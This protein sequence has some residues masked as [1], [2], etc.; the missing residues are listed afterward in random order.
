LRL[1]TVFGSELIVNPITALLLVLIIIVHTDGHGDVVR[2]L[3][4]AGADA[5]VHDALLVTPLHLAA[6][7]EPDLML[8]EHISNWDCVVINVSSK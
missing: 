1:S 3:L 7:G 4:E 2:L 6:R 5:N 8:V